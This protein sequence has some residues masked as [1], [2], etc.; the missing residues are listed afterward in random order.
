MRTLFAALV[1][2]TAFTV[3]P[4]AAHAQDADRH[5]VS[6]GQLMTA[7][8]IDATGIRSLEPEQLAALNSWLE[9]Y[10]VAI[11]RRVVE[12]AEEDFAP[13]QQ[14]IV[15]QIDGGFDGWVGNTVF[16][17]K[18][19]QI[20]QQVSPSAKYHTAQ[21][22][23]VTITRSPYLMRVDGVGIEIEVQRIK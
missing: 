7:D 18:N 23:R 20:W 9:R 10:R 19:G 4:T 8:E 6:I 1:A 12:N 15:T 16:R 17:L 5:P 2:V 11:E 21:E 3:T 22:P 14:T 13:A